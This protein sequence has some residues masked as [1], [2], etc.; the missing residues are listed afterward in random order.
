MQRILVHH[1]HITRY[2]YTNLFS[3]FSSSQKDSSVFIPYTLLLNVL[4]RFSDFIFILIHQPGSLYFSSNSQISFYQSIFTV[5][6]EFLCISVV[7]FDAGDIDSLNCHSVP[8]QMRLFV[9]YVFYCRLLIPFRIYIRSV[10][11]PGYHFPDPKTVKKCTEKDE[12]HS[13]LRTRESENSFNA[14]K[15]GLPSK[16]NPF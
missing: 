3:F 10:T 2:L 7:L 6:F 13:R 11:E 5:L 8:I 16:M 9:L 15:I 1:L 4:N 14:V 12:I